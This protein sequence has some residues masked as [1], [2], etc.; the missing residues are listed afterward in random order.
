MS[1]G[2]WNNELDK[3]W[4]TWLHGGWKNRLKVGGFKE[5]IQ[6]AIAEVG[7]TSASK[8][9]AA[10]IALLKTLATTINNHQKQFGEY[11][12]TPNQFAPHHNETKEQTTLDT[13]LSNSISIRVTD[14]E[15]YF[16]LKDKTLP[17]LEKLS[18]KYEKM[19]QSV[20]ALAKD[21][22]NP[23]NQTAYKECAKPE[24]F[25]AR[26]NYEFTQQVQEIH[27]EKG[28][29]NQAITNMTL[30]V[31]NARPAETIKNLGGPTRTAGFFHKHKTDDSS[32]RRKSP[33]NEDKEG[34]EDYEMQDI[35][36]LNSLR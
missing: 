18:T 32:G 13:L 23:T 31:D 5:K 30:A 1:N 22:D 33:R 14:P 15:A 11:L 17:E 25:N 29:L 21:P 24:F 10:A 6:A 20:I 34:E 26:N 2:G 35:S 19:L 3:D 28:G 12:Y 4:K 8:T 27:G 36:K 9:T 16:L 7:S